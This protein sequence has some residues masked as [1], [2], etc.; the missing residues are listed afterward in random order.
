M[1]NKKSLAASPDLLRVSGL[2]EQKIAIFKNFISATI[3][4]KDMIKEHNVE[5][6][7]NIIARR[8]D[9]ITF[10][11]RLDDEIRMIREANPFS[12]E[13]LDPETRKRVRSFTKMLENLINKTL[14]LN[15][16]CEAAAE[17]ELH[18]LRT[19]LSGLNHREKCF[20]GSRGKSWEPR[21]LDVKT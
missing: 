10:I 13:M 9:Q 18:K 16:D 21:F 20:K 15:Q 12:G 5:A 8:R 3:S 2:L 17:D 11:N 6:V 4:L 14:R 1:T 7:E 19:G